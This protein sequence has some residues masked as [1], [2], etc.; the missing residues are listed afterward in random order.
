CHPDVRGT[1][2]VWRPS[3]D[4]SLQ[5]PASDRCLTAADGRLLLRDCSGA[6]GQHWAT[7]R[8]SGPLTGVAGQ[9]VDIA[10]AATANGSAVQLYHCN[11]TGA[12]DWSVQQDGS[13]RALGKCLD[14]T[15]GW[16]AA[17]TAAQLYDCNGTGAQKWLPRADGTLL[18][19]VSNRCLDARDGS[20]AD[21]TRLQ[22]W[23]CQASPN[24]LWKLPG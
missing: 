14:V 15:N 8:P 6:P 1:E 18:N 21:W 7:P 12:Q 16:T 10:R 2:Q 23:D 20:S 9:C 13:L 11:S 22:I 3:P 5:N 24:Q 17:G 4:N 19:P